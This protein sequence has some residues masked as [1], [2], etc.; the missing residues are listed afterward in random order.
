MKYLS[1]IAAILLLSSSLGMPAAASPQPVS[2]Y[3]MQRFEQVDSTCK[4]SKTQDCTYFSVKYPVLGSFLAP[5]IQA[6]INQQIQHELLNL[7]NPSGLQAQSQKFLQDYRQ[8]QKEN[9]DYQIPWVSEIQISIAFLNRDMLGLRL[10][11]YSFTGGAHGITNTVFRNYDLHTGKRLQIQD[12]FKPGYEKALN[13]QAEQIFRAQKGLTRW[14]SLEEAGYWF[15]NNHFAINDNLLLSPE[16]LIIHFN[17]YEI[18]PYV[19]G[20]TEIQVDYPSVSNWIK[21]W[22]QEDSLISR[23]Q[24]RY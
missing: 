12:I 21:G 23:I 20:P 13:Q 17:V 6:L 3:T 4:A 24:R 10:D 14:Q 19:D 22:G 11:S 9:P 16:G 18:A 7:K 8:F 2:L 15:K 1:F 5:K